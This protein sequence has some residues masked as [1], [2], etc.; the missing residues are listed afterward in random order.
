MY[1]SSSLWSCHH[2]SMYSYVDSRSEVQGKLKLSAEAEG[3]DLIFHIV[4]E[5]VKNIKR[6]LKCVL[7]ILLLTVNEKHL[8]GIMFKGNAVI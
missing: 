3:F 1:F 4:F 2:L 6:L 5:R 7:F 8:L